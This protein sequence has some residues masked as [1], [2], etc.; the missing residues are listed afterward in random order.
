MKMKPSNGSEKNWSHLMNCRSTKISI[1]KGVIQRIHTTFFVAPK[2]L[3][4]IRKII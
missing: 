4:G 2:N 3:L 1:L